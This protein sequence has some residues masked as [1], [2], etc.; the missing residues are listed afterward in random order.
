MRGFATH[1]E[2]NTPSGARAES[3]GSCEQP[4]RKEPDMAKEKT[5]ERKKRSKR[6]ERKVKRKQD[7][8][9]FINPLGNTARVRE[10]AHARKR[11]LPCT[12]SYAEAGEAS[13]EIVC[14]CFPHCAKD[15]AL[16][17]WYCRHFNRRLIIGKAYYYAS[18]HRQGEVRDGVRRRIA[19]TAVE[20]DVDSARMDFAL[21]LTVR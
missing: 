6:K 14:N 16:W 7:G 2:A 5:K 13:A 8:G 20:M 18:C 3:R 15:F 1:G 9:L 10:G 4:E 19:Q 12:C 21:A 11:R 17:A